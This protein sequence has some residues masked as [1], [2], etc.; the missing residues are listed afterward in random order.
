MTEPGEDDASQDDNDDGGLEALRSVHWEEVGD[1]WNAMSAPAA[2][3]MGDEPEPGADLDED[4]RGAN[5][6]A[7]PGEQGFQVVRIPKS[8]RA[9]MHLHP[10]CPVVPLGTQDGIYFYL[11]VIGQM[12]PIKEKDHSLNTIKG[13]FSIRQ[14]YLIS[15]WPR[16][17]EDTDGGWVATGWKPE[18]AASALMDACG[19]RGVWDPQDRMRGAGAWKGPD[20]E[21]IIHFGKAIGVWPADGSKTD[22]IL[23]SVL[24]DMVYPTRPSLPLPAKQKEPPDGAAHELLAYLKSWNW[25]RPDV[26]PYLMLGW[27][28]AAYLGAYLKWHPLGWLVG[29]KGTGKSTLLLMIKCLLGRF[30]FSTANATAAAIYQNVRYDSRAVSIDE[31]EPDEENNRLKAQQELA[32][33]AA[34]GSPI[35]RGGSENNPVE[36][37]QRAPFLF[38]SINMPGLNSADLSRLAVLSLKPLLDTPPEGAKAPPEE[39]EKAMDRVMGPL[40]S[41]VLRRVVDGSPRLSEVLKAYRAAMRSSGHS[42]R[43]ADVF[44]TLLSCAHIVLSDDL[45]KATNLEE[46]GHRLKASELAEL[47]TD[48]AANMACL[49]HLLTSLLDVKQGGQSYSVGHWVDLLVSN[50]HDSSDGAASG[51]KDVRSV[52]RTFGLDVRPHPGDPKGQLYLWVAYR[53]QQMVKLF[54]GSPWETKR[55]AGPWVDKLRSLE[56]AMGNVSFHCGGPDKAVLI[57]IHYCQ[58]GSPEGE[59]TNASAPGGS[60]DAPPA[61]HTH[62][63]EAST[64]CGAVSA[65]S[66]T[67]SGPDPFDMSQEP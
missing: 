67:G 17:K 27:I 18:E 43:G 2:D 62:G 45:P 16:A 55:G 36:F 46:W 37:N 64:R 38:A 63:S 56:G 59:H 9:R 41:R 29:D 40:G 21:L 8:M 20:G 7:P 3:D 10:D 39:D 19:R 33:A 53:N 11:D 57:P 42:G 66:S 15:T 30:L 65:Q 49:L 34:S 35:H 52:L 61:A 14:E 50:T 23:P 51:A 48:M 1:D 13:L 26:D 5:D 4:A 25:V 44:G 6:D 58:E 28:I 32:R 31:A 22:W 54:A 60:P 24:G 12:R 47:S